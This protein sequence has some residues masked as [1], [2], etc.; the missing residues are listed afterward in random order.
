MGMLNL[1]PN[2]D[3]A[4]GE[5]LLRWVLPTACLVFFVWSMGWLF[6]D[7]KRLGKNP[8]VVCFL[9]A[10]TTWP[11]SLLSWLVF[12]PSAPPPS[13]RPPLEEATECA[14]CRGVIPAGESRCPACGWSYETSAPVAPGGE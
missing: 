3:A 7:A 6:G 14:K 11:V 5:D 12:R 8:F 13:P 10:I 4:S 9:V 2:A 1:E